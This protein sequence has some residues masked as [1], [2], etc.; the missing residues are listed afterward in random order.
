M[1]RRLLKWSS[2]FTKIL[3]ASKLILQKSIFYNR[4]IIH[5]IPADRELLKRN[6]PRKNKKVPYIPAYYS[7]Y[8]I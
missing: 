6:K 8:E 4:L 7:V 3:A 1:L 5:D 2:Y